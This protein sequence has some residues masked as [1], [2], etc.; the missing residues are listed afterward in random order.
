MGT[1]N[2]EELTPD[3]SDL[4]CSEVI[5]EKGLSTPSSLPIPVPGRPGGGEQDPEAYPVKALNDPVLYKD[6][7]ILQNLLR[8]EENYLP[9]TPD[10]FKYVQKDIS[11]PMRK[12]VGDWMLQL[13]QELSAAPEVF[14]L[15]MN[16]MDRF[17]SRCRV[18]KSKLQLVGAVCLLV[19]SKFR[20]T[21]PI[22]GER[23]IFYTDFSI[24]SEEIKDWELLLLQELRWELSSVTP[25]E[26]LDQII[27]RIGIHSS[28]DLV[29]LKQ[30]AETI[31]VLSIL[32]YKFS[33]LTPSLM[34]S[35][36]LFAAL[37]VISNDPS[38]L[39]EDVASYREIGLRL[40]TLT[41]IVASDLD[42]CMTQMEKILPDYLKANTTPI[43][44]ALADSTS[45][46]KSLVSESSSNP[47]SLESGGIYDLDHNH[48][49]PSSST[50]DLNPTQTSDANLSIL[51][52]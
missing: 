51:V 42:L 29:R 30:R 41:H 31:I 23:L 49:H 15:A 8:L 27:H 35:A 4:R 43:E 7:R 11:P 18:D 17:L 25:L 22:L 16:Y 37:K 40:Q 45:S 46:P 13:C 21:R 47:S 19:A 20:E 12:I 36:G 38:V 52:N 34:A 26:F 39:C 1:Y 33:Y 3:L 5:D 28:I 2:K 6:D 50:S 24:T 48:H 44:C 32:E 9:S 10:Y 14:C